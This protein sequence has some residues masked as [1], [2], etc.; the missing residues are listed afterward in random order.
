MPYSETDLM[1]IDI[2]GGSISV[3]L[4]HNMWMQKGRYM[5]FIKEL[6]R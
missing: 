3:I 5:N 4:I 6:I 2:N 1:L